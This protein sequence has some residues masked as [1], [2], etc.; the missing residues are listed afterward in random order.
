MYL[1]QILT[2]SRNQPR[3]IPVSIFLQRTS[4]SYPAGHLSVISYLAM[5]AILYPLMLF[6]KTDEEPVSENLRTSFTMDELARNSAIDVHLV[7]GTSIPETSSVGLVLHKTE[8]DTCFQQ[9]YEHY[10]LSDGLVCTSFF[11]I[12]FSFC[13]INFKIEEECNAT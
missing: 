10:P 8:L 13:R 5:N 3:L 1:P 9:E 7:S 12:V 6:S 11:C 4:S 2:Y